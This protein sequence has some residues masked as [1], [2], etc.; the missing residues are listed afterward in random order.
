MRIKA[1]TFAN[2]IVGHES[3]TKSFLDQIMKNVEKQRRKLGVSNSNCSVGHMRTK[4][5]GG[6]IMTLT[7]Q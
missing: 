5:P 1:K 3:F 4:Q 6:R 2:K 7:Q